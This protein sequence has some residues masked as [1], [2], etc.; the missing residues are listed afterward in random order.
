MAMWIWRFFSRYFVQQF[1][2]FLFL[3]PGSRSTSL[4]ICLLCFSLTVVTPNVSIREYLPLS[5]TNFPTDWALLIITSLSL[6]MEFTRKICLA[7]KNMTEA[8][9][10]V[11]KMKVELVLKTTRIIHFQNELFLEGNLTFTQVYIFGKYLKHYHKS[12]LLIVLPYWVSGFCGLIW[13]I[14]IMKNKGTNIYGK[15]IKH[16]F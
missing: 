10:K 6:Q 11:F 4:L 13:I 15:L 1:K 2:F 8:E 7:M 9:I 16:N 5:P 12:I 14:V 3:S